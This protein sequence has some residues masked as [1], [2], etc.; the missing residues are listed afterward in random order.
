MK[1]KLGIICLGA[2]L[3]AGCGT[4]KLENGKEAVITFKDDAKISVDDLYTKLKDEYG[5]NALISMIDTY[6][7]EK[8]FPDYVATAK[9][10][11][12]NTVKSAI[13]NY[14]SEDQ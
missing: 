10:S 4:P 8:E 12:E 3:L 11:A 6:I 13:A 2:L 5:L 1:K 7:L 9:T 14:E